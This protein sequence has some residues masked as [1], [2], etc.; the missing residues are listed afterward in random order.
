[1]L[2]ICRYGLHLPYLQSHRDRSLRR[3][4]LCCLSTACS[5]PKHNLLPLQSRMPAFASRGMSSDD[6][7]GEIYPVNSSTSKAHI[8]TL[9]RAAS[10][11]DYPF[12]KKGFS[13]M[14]PA[15]SLIQVKNRAEKIPHLQ[16]KK[17]NQKHP[18]FSSLH[19]T[20]QCHF[21]VLHFSQI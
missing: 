9:N 13:E 19:P 14:R 17:S 1:M 21:C 16:D 18:G 3:I 12:L 2:A 6:R 10:S 11:T 4:S 5:C 15:L 20:W 8:H 7:S